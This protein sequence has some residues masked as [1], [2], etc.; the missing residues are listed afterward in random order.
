MGTPVFFIASSFRVVLVTPLNSNTLRAF[1]SLEPRHQSVLSIDDALN[2]RNWTVA[3]AAG[4]GEVPEL[5]TVENAIP[6][7]TA[8]PGLASAWSVDLRLDRRVIL[9]TT[10]RVTASTALVSTFG[11][12]M[13]ASPLNRGDGPGI[14]LVRPRRPPRTSRTTDGLDFFYDTFAAA[15]RLDPRRD[16]DVHGGDDARRKRIIRRLISGRGR[17]KHLPT[18]GLGLQ[19]KGPLNTSALAELRA[20]ATR[21][22]LEEGDIAAVDVDVVRILNGIIVKV[23]AR[24]ISGR[25][26][27]LTFEVPVEGP[28]VVA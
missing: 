20:E 11:D 7:P 4:V 12:P 18:Y 26:V 8:I 13:A 24:P 27:E 15:W 22:I 16:V 2:R 19:A 17:F 5:E 9:G 23:R 3:V 28:V 6:Q 14:A 25:G 1:L 10:Y 21:Q